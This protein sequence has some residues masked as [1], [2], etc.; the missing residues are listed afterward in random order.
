MCVTKLLD[1]KLFHLIQQIFKRGL[2]RNMDKGHMDKAKGVQGSRVGGGDGW[3]VGEWR[4]N[5]DNCT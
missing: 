1:I 5:G 3:A 2:S 4:G